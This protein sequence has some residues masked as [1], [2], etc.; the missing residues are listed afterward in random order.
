MGLVIGVFAG[1][2]VT[3][4]ADE[5]GNNQM[6]G[7]TE[8]FV[9]WV[10]NGAML[11]DSRDGI[12]PTGPYYGSITVQNLEEADVTVNYEVLATGETDQLQLEEWETKTLTVEALFDETDEV[13]GS[14]VVLSTAND[15][16]IAAVQKQASGAAPNEEARTSPES[17][18]V[19]GYTAMTD[20]SGDSVLPIVQTNNNWNTL[21]RLTN[22][23]E[24]SADVEVSLNPAGGEGD[25]PT[26]NLSIDAGDTETINLLGDENGI[27]DG[28]TG[29]ARIS[30][31]GSVGAVAERA[32]N[33]TDMLIMN[34]ALLAENSSTQYAPLV[35][36]EYNHWNTGISIANLAEVENDISIT[37][38]DRDGEELNT[39]SLT[40]PANGMDY[41]Y[42]PASVVANDAMELDGFVGS[43]VI[44]GDH[45]FRGAVDE[46][47]YFGDDPDTGHAMSYMVEDQAATAGETLAMPIF[48]SGGEDGMGDTTG[49]QLFN[50]TDQWVAGAVRFITQFGFEYRQ[51]LVVHLEP[52]EGYTVYPYEIPGFPE[53]VHGSALVQVY[54][55]DGAITAAANNVNYAVANDGSA[56]F[57]LMLTGEAG[58]ETPEYILRTDPRRATNEWFTTFSLTATLL[59]VDGNPVENE[60]VLI[61][62]DPSIE[63]PPGEAEQITTNAEG[64]VVFNDGFTRGGSELVDRFIVIY[65]GFDP[66]EAWPE[67]PWI[68]TY[69]WKTWVEGDTQE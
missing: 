48:Q 18:I 43:A 17:G 42:T 9:P 61:M 3:G 28:W 1:T 56:S 27:P 55:G 69:A 4:S 40:V 6:D 13:D 58:P 52:G 66:G 2:L 37:Y 49:L 63:G 45:P 39:D 36:Q 44:T 11:D 41:V 24:A 38:Y 20:V 67:D 5:H 25:A 16:R 65:P 30:T 59:D 12:D 50:P 21:I 34:A 26:F 10:P 7:A 14:G 62:V 15:A 68:E 29:S 47:K 57:N 60:E 33:E 35:F 51:P 31:E 54:A 53:N 64:Q 22:F 46:V 23:G 8:L 19:G 32:K